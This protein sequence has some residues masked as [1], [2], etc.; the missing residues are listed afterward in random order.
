MSDP[1]QLQPPWT[2]SH[3]PD[4]LRLTAETLGFLVMWW[5]SLEIDLDRSIM[6]LLQAEGLRPGGL[7]HEIVGHIDFREKLQILRSVAFRIKPTQKWFSDVDKLL[8]HIDNELRPER[9]RMIHDR[10]FYGHPIIA[11]P[12][13]RRTASPRLRRPQSRQQV[14][15]REAKRIAPEDIWR[16]CNAVRDAG[17][18]IGALIDEIGLHDPSPQK[19]S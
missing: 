16:L 15:E 19:R 5:S 10:W 4:F 11:E 13:V 8:N 9:N 2:G 17:F 1:P 3:F 14:L 12:M 18:A 7:H 6:L